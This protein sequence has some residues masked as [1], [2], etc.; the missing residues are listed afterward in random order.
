[1]KLNDIMTIMDRI[2]PLRLMM[3]FDNSG[4]QYGH[5]D[6][7]VERILLALDVTDT[8]LDEAIAIGADMIIT[9]HPLIFHPIKRIDD[10][11]RVGRLLIR[12]IQADIAVYSAH[13]NLD[14][15][16]GGIC[17]QL[18]DMFGLADTVKVDVDEG[19]EGY[20]RLGNIQPMQLGELARQA[21]DKLAACYVRHTGNPNRLISRLCVASGSGGSCFAKAMA[22]G[23]ECVITGDVKYDPALDYP[24]MGMDIIDAGHFSTEI[25]AIPELFRRL[26][27]ELDSIKCV[28]DVQIA[29]AS[30]DPYISV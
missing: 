23:A 9:H 20:A 22:M 26:Q 21:K 7:Q 18:A 16:D 13:T 25:I 15:V 4:L 5:C 2:A 8:V 30:V 6:K 24:P 3:D 17:D 12:L 19:G 14:V 28:I 1:M 10:N 29:K 11:S 27:S